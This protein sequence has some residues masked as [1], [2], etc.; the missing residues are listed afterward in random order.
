[1]YRES[2]AKLFLALESVVGQFENKM[3][4]ELKPCPYRH[5]FQGLKAREI[6]EKVLVERTLALLQRPEAEA[7]LILGSLSGA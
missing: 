2:D 7:P 5:G 6:D 1:L 4:S 3:T